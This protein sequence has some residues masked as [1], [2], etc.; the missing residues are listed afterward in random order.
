MAPFRG[1]LRRRP[2][3]AAVSRGRAVR[4]DV[5]AALWVCSN[6][7]PPHAQSLARRAPGSAR[8]QDLVDARSV[9]TRGRAGAP[10]IAGNDARSAGPTT[11][12]GEDQAVG[13]ACPWRTLRAPTA[14]RGMRRSSLAPSLPGDDRPVDDAVRHAQAHRRRDVANPPEVLVAGLMAT[15]AA[16]LPVIALAQ[17]SS[18]PEQRSQD[19]EHDHHQGRHRDLL[20]GLG[21]RPGRHVLARLA[22]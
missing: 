9:G 15:I 2:S 20:Q 22:A 7:S 19:H 10:E 5:F 6:T 1:A 13:G 14:R 8:Q 16:G 12:R 17:M 4:N 21:Q 11:L 3:R 18:H